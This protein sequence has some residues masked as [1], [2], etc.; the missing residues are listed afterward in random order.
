MTGALFFILR[1][2]DQSGNLK[3]FASFDAGSATTTRF[4]SSKV[5]RPG[6]VERSFQLVSHLDDFGL[7]PVEE[8]RENVDTVPIGEL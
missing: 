4:L 7:R 5:T 2:V 3:G 8:W 6:Q 1:R